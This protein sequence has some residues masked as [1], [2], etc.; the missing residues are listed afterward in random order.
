[1]V[2]GISAILGVGLVILWLMGISTSGVAGWLSWLDGAA[3]IWAFVIA[4]SAT[5]EEIGEQRSGSP[6]ALSMGLF[7][8]WIIALATGTIAWMTWWTFAFA[9]A[10]LALGIVAAQRRPT[11]TTEEEEK[12]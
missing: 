4:G 1:M 5:T 12:D 8:L 2:R 11:V 3:A 6:I 9:C 10:F 7:A